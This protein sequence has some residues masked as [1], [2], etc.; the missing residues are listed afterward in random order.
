[1]SPGP[2]TGACGKMRLVHV[3][4]NLGSLCALCVPT[5]H[6]E[7]IFTRKECGFVRGA[8]AGALYI[9]CACT[10]LFVRVCVWS[11]GLVAS[12]RCPRY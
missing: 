10:A 5:S 11:S 1:M 7:N 12:V 4:V 6:D 2:Q 3:G 8:F 9:V